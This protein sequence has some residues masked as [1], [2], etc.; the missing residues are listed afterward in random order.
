M[1]TEAKVKLVEWFDERFYRLDYEE[2]GEQKVTYIPSVTT[3]LGIIAKPFLAHW[4]GDIGNREADLRVWEAGERGTRIHH[5]WYTLTTGGAVIY[6]PYQRPNYTQSE[7]DLI[8]SEYVG[9]VAI[10]RYQ[11]EMYDIWKLERWLEIVNPVFK[12]S[13]LTV[14]SLEDKDAG[15]LDNLLEIA[16]GDYMVNGAKPL[17]IPGGLY[18]LDLKSGKFVDYQAFMQTAPYANCVKKMGL[19]E[20]IGTL[21]LHTQASTRKGIEGLATILRSKEE[22][23][24]DYQDYR[25]ASALWERKNANAKPT[26]FEFPALI[27][28]RKENE[29][30][31]NVA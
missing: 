8:T 13:E 17:H 27:T 5:S 4:R 9:N 26:I 11:D 24:Q 31:K 30:G 19:G 14:Y 18:V 16:E 1:T 7:I 20:P 29:N 23:E 2:E 15:T 28:L 25:L 6:Q 3:K 10:V 21:I 12:A 22:M